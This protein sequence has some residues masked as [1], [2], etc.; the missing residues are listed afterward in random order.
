MYDRYHRP[1]VL[2]L[3]MY[4]ITLTLFWYESGSIV[5]G[6]GFGLVSATLKTIWSHIHH[7]YFHTPPDNLKVLE[8]IES[9]ENGEAV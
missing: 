9:A 7:H 5:K 1:I 8:E 3:G 6:L 4:V 2:W